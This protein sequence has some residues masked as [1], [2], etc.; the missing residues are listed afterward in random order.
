MENENQNEIVES[1]NTEIA[2]EQR[3]YNGPV[4][5][6]EAESYITSGLVSTAR[7]YVAIG[8][9]LRRI[10]DGKL[11]EEEG[12]QNFE[13]Y[14]HEK[15]GKDKGWASKCIKV[16]QQLSKDGDSPLLDSRYRD[17]STYQLV[18]LAYMTEEQREQATPEQTV[19]QLQEIRKP[20]KVV[21]SQPE[22]P[23]EEQ[24]PGQMDITD[25][26]G[27][28]PENPAAVL[29]DPDT[30]EPEVVYQM[31]VSEMISAEDAAILA[32]ES[33]QDA[34]GKQQTGTCA[35]RDGFPCSLDD[36]AKQKAG[37]GEDCTHSCCW[38]CVN[39]GACNIECYASANRPELQKPQQDPEICCE[40][41]AGQETKEQGPKEKKSPMDDY[42]FR[43]KQCD[44]LAR[45]L[46]QCWK[47]WF[48][49]DFQN[50][51]LNVVES[52]KQIKEKN[53]RSSDRTWYFTGPDGE[54]M[55]ANVFDDYIQFW[56]N[57]CLGN[58]G[59]FYLCV[60]IQRMWQEM[61]IEKTKKQSGQIIDQND[62]DQEEPDPGTVYEEPPEIIND[63][64]YT[65]QYF[66][67][68]EQKKLN[69]LLEAFKDTDPEDIPRELFA[70]QKTIVAALAGMVCDLENEELKKQLEEEK[71][72]QPE[73]PILKNN[74]QRAA[75][76]DGYDTWPIWI[77]TEETGE[78]YY[79][80]D[81]PDASLVVKVYFHKCFDYKAVS[82]KWEDRFRDAWGDPEYY[83]ILDGKHFRDCR[84]N[85][86]AL[87]DYLKE[88]QKKG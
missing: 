17:Y 27:F 53:N 10:R 28:M 60:A 83:L 56:G 82:E 45:K 81:L 85:R 73:L 40:N 20:E 2:P 80:Y 78:R 46:I 29:P 39:H 3:Y 59:W 44:A 49:K 21:T 37:T 16:N 13:Q 41:A 26:P 64:P 65:P 36:S 47:P 38:E 9:W 86:S 76:V 35:H 87:I 88:I 74:D 52:E 24:L 31:N 23:A 51:V 50:R 4:T 84:T 57:E 55:H 66:L 67:S 54:L 72:Q 69:D 7:N 11:Y 33:G 15:Y 30:G 25:F 62:N 12:H 71:P 22:E 32:A 8:Y 75:F 5:L 19:K 1:Q 79:R 6:E 63:N 34:A 70:H 14:V 18:E 48:E 68:L 43:E 61:A 77:D 42:G 58:C